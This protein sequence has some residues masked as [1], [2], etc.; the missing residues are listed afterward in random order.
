MYS[1]PVLKVCYIILKSINILLL[2]RC[3]CL[4]R[5]HSGCL[6]TRDNRRRRQSLDNSLCLGCLSCLP[7]CSL[8]LVRYLSRCI[9][10]NSGR[11]L[12]VLDSS[13]HCWRILTCFSCLN[14]YLSRCLQPRNSRRRLQVLDSSLCIG[15]GYSRSCRL[16]ALSVAEPV[17]NVSTEIT[18][19]QTNTKGRK[20]PCKPVLSRSGKEAGQSIGTEA[21]SST[22]QDVL[23]YLRINSRLLIQAHHLEICLFIHV[24]LT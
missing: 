5:H 23:D 18:C 22:E 9:H 19:T 3:S 14:C 7:S 11:R 10:G 1:F 17:T 8:H 15:I 4:S 13:L 21:S 20:K 16:L 6:Q 2:T 24:C 12:Q